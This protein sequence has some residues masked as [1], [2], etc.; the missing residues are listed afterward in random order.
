MAS[1][2]HW[3]LQVVVATAG[4]WWFI[5]QYVNKFPSWLSDWRLPLVFFSRRRVVLVLPFSSFA[6]GVCGGRLGLCHLSA[7]SLSFRR[8]L[9]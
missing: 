3:F 7:A 9:C 8:P 5:E 6:Y 2:R 1:R 4:S